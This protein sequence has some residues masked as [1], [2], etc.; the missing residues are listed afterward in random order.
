M[1]ITNACIA[2]FYNNQVYL[3][4]EKPNRKNGVVAEWWNFPGGQIDP[5]ESA[6]NSAFREFGEETGQLKGGFNLEQWALTTGNVFEQYDYARPGRPKH[7]SIFWCVCTVQ[8]I[9]QFRKNDE[10]TQGLWCDV[11]NLPSPLK[12]ESITE[13]IRNLTSKKRLGIRSAFS[14]FEPP[15]QGVSAAAWRNRGDGRAGTAAGESAFEPPPPTYEDSLDCEVLP[16]QIKSMPYNYEDSLKKALE[17]SLLDQGGGG[18]RN[19]KKLKSLRNSKY[20]RKSRRNSRRNSTRNSTR[21]SRKSIR[22]LR[23]NSR[24]LRINSK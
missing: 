19:Y 20:S 8:P 24:K 7:T 11:D 4:K 2:L 9:F 5:G 14:A 15:S 6:K 12:F 17:R 10:T 22:N 21:N 18:G 1:P 13:L 3:I 16:H 23:M